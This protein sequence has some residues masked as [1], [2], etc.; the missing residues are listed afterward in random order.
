MAQLRRDYQ[1]FVER[2]AEVIAIG[3]EDRTRFLDFWQKHQM[4]FIGIPDPQ[5]KAADLYGQEVV[6][7]KGGRMPAMFAIDKQGMVRFQHRGSSMADIPK[8]ED[9]L[10][11]LDRLNAGSP[12]EPVS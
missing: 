1:K 7:I 8:D 12:A 2:D 3:P 11:L 6:L 4:P 5:H 10:A 9:I